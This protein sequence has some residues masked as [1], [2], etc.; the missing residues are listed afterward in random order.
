M[1]RRLLVLLLILASC[2]GKEASQ[3]QVSTVKKGT[4]LEELVEQ[5]TIQAVNSISVTA[6]SISYRYGALKIAKIIDDGQEVEKADTIL[7]FDPSEIKKSIVQAEQQLEIAKAEYEKLKSTQRS[8]L[9]DLEADLELAQT[10]KEISQINFETST[11]EPEATK[12][13]IELKL[14]SASIALER[15]REQIDNKKIIHKEDLIQKSVAINQITVTLKDA[16]KSLNSLFVVSPAR[17]IAIKEDNWNTGQ[18]W[19]VNDQPY[20]GSKIIEL[21]DLAAMRAEVKINEVDISKILPGQRVE[22]RPDAYSDS[23]YQGRVESVANL[24][25]KK[26][27]KSKIK[28][29]PVQIR[30]A[31]ES[32]KLLPGLS[33]SCKIIVSEIPD[34]IYIPLESLF[35]DQMVE[36]VYLKSGKGFKKKEVK[37]GAVNSD[38]AIITEGLREKDV[39][40]LS[41]PFLKKEEVKKKAPAAGKNAGL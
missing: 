3:V 18:K 35:K 2:R 24:A 31:G 7:I 38:F 10:S 5:G 6:P 30:I 17:G 32:K 33:V 21:P 29:F 23:L 25:Q 40:A 20:S 11:Y 28:I 19:A 27:Y 22:I 36:Y 12:K 8:E 9:E 37:T 1:I 26:D 4:F 15:A 41:N 13:E 16:N 39:V 14:K 34:V